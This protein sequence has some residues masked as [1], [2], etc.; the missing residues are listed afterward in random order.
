MVSYLKRKPK[1]A[2]QADI[3]RAT[4]IKPAIVSILLKRHGTHFKRDQARG[5][6]IR[7]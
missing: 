6:L 1:G 3:A 4:G 7:V 5:G 2:S